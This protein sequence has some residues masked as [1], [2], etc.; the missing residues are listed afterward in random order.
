M[1]TLNA[2]QVYNLRGRCRR[3][4]LENDLLL[5]KF[6]L[7]YQNGMSLDMQE[8]LLQLMQLDD[9]ILLDLLLGKVHPHQVEVPTI[10]GAA[11]KTLEL[12]R[13]TILYPIPL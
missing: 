6:F 4:I 2:L 10:E 1:E 11:L 9:G 8:G 12:I 3:G 7:T 13:Q 5:E